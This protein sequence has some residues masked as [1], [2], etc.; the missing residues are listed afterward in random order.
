MGSEMCIR[1]R[2]T[3]AYQ[4]DLVASRQRRIARDQLGPRGFGGGFGQRRRSVS[5]TVVSNRPTQVEHWAGLLAQQ[6]HPDYEVIAVMHGEPFPDG[7]QAHL[8]ERIGDRLT[9]LSASSDHNLGDSLNL[10]AEAAAGDLVVKWDDDDYYSTSHLRDLAATYETTRAHLVGKAAEFVYLAGIDVTVRRGSLSR[11][12]FSPSLAGPTLTI[13]RHDLFEIGGWPSVPR[14][15]DTRLIERVKQ[16][17]GTSFRASGFGFMLMR[18]AD[19]G[20]HT[21]NADA[22]YFLERATEQRRGLALGFAD[23]D[24]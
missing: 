18:N 10:A 2:V 8:R 5:V 15:V 19:P 3:D 17:G 7:A 12:A 13:G 16:A 24:V 23:I 21:W 14:Q 4:R 11:E 6:D 9:L 22:D 1:D 20:T